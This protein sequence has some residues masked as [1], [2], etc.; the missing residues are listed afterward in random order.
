MPGRISSQLTH[1]PYLS[2]TRP[3]K[4]MWFHPSFSLW[5]KWCFLLWTR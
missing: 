5:I 4:I 1:F 3:A 2:N